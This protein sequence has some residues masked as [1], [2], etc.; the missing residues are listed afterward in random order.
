MN[1]KIVFAGG[2]VYYAA[3]FAV[4]MILGYFIHAPET[5]V[6]AEAYRATASFWRPE[7]SANPPDQR[8][9]WE[10]WIP[11]GVLSS[12]LAA[13]VY[14]VV[15]SSLTGAS[16]LRGLKFGVIALVFSIINALGYHGVFNLPGK[17]WMWWIAGAAVMYLAAGPVLGLVAHKLAPVRS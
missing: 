8:L 6:L 4:S 16:W 2:I 17:I 1:W 14:S 3:L 15:R 7:L 9:M 12:F 11:S 13:G 10:M 5:G